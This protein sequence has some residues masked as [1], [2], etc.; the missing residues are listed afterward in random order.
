M[1]TV[2][3]YVLCESSTPEQGQYKRRSVGR[4]SAPVFDLIARTS[5]AAALK[6]DVS[7]VWLFGRKN[8]KIHALR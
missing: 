6:N 4:D 1:T 3:I 8:L 7:T 2:E 5:L